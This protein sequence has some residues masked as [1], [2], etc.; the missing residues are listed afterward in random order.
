MIRKQTKISSRGLPCEEAAGIKRSLP[1]GL[2]ESLL[3]RHYN[4]LLCTI[5]LFPRLENSP[6]LVLCATLLRPHTQD[7]LINASVSEPMTTVQLSA[8]PH[9]VNSHHAP[10]V[11]L[12]LCWEPQLIHRMRWAHVCSR[13]AVTG[14]STQRAQG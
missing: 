10:T 12:D 2:C 8:L 5:V 13:L 1:P 7:E 4:F 3:C 9:S 14:L 11:C 6:F